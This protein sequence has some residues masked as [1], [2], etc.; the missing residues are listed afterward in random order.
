[1]NHLSHACHS[2]SIP[3]LVV[4]RTYRLFLST[5]GGS[6]FSHLAS[7]SSSAGSVRGRTM[8]KPR[9]RASVKYQML[10][11]TCGSCCFQSIEEAT[12]AA[13]RVR[14]TPSSQEPPRTTRLYSVSG[15]T[16]GSFTTPSALHLP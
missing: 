10:C 5:C 15:A 4:S 11:G 9:K 2:N 7:F 1:I 8:R 12:R 6:D 16:S 14:R 13:E 3:Q